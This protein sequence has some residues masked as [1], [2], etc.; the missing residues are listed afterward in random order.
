MLVWSSLALAAPDPARPG[1]APAEDEPGVQLVLRGLVEH[2]NEPALSAVYKSGTWLGGLGLVVPVVGPLGLDLELGF[3]RL[4]GTGST[5]ELAP[6]SALVELG[7]PMGRLDGFVG[8]GPAW[9]VFGERVE[10][11]T[12]GA[13]QGARIAAELRAGLRLDTGLVDPPSPPTPQGLLQALQLEVYVARRAQ[14]PGEAE[15]LQLGAWRG[16]VGLGMEF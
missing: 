15:G 4:K 10:G 8:V 12:E 9:T 11:S 14:M 16:S 5:M 7:A 13:V 1:A 2:W 3:G 6:L